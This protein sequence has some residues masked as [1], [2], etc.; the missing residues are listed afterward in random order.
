MSSLRPADVWHVFAAHG[1]NEIERWPKCSRKI[2]IPCDHR[3]QSHEVTEQRTGLETH[4]SQQ[5][6]VRCFV[7]RQYGL[8]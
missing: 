7:Q 3:V 2:A 6:R 1:R 4:L 5:I 8:R